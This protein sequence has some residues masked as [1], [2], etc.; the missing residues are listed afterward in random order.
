MC[1][2]TS[3]NY[4]TF[5][6]WQLIIAMTMMRTFTAWTHT[7]AAA[8]AVAC[9]LLRARLRATAAVV[10]TSRVEQRQR[11]RQREGLEERPAMGGA[12]EGCIY[13]A[14]VDK[15]VSGPE[16]RGL[17]CLAGSP[18]I[19]LAALKGPVCETWHHVWLLYWLGINI[20][21]RNTW[22]EVHT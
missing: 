7:Q 15:K 16:G 1:L 3:F 12:V 22:I 17:S 21:L 14:T 13:R 11:F 20:L 9:S 4:I 5:H 2:K 6:I 18:K 8:Q 10:L 19:W